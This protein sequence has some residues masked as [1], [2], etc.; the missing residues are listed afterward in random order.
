N[1]SVGI[2]V[3][4]AEGIVSLLERFEERYTEE[5]LHRGLC[6]Y[7]DLERYA[8]KLLKNDETAA[9]VAADIDEIFIDEYQDVNEIQDAIFKMISSA[10]AECRRFMV[11]DVKQSIYGFRGADPTIFD[12]Y[13]RSFSEGKEG[14]LIFMSENFR[15]DEGIVNFTNDVTGRLFSCGN[16]SFTEDDALRH[17]KGTDGVSFGN[18]KFIITERGDEAVEAE[19]ESVAAEAEKLMRGGRAADDIVILMRSAKDRAAVFENALRRHNIPVRNDTI[20]SFFECP[21]VLLMLCLIGM[22]N[23]PLYDIYTAGALRS[24]VFGFS[25]DEL[26][27]VKGGGDEPLYR[28][29]I[30][31]AED[32]SEVTDELR[33]KCADAAEIIN[34]WRECA[35]RMPSDEFV[36]MLYRKTGMEGIIAS[37]A[38]MSVGSVPLDVRRENLTSFYEYAKRF[39]SGS[40]RGV[41]RFLEYINDMIERGVSADI[42]RTAGGGCVK[43]MTIHQSKGLEFPVVFLSGCGSKRNA[44]DT[45]KSLLF[46]RE[47]GVAM[48][49][50][51][52]P[53]RAAVTDTLLRASASAAIEKKNDS[54]EMRILYVGLTRAKEQLYVTAETR[55]TADELLSNAACEARFFS[56]HT[57]REKKTPLEWILTAAIGDDGRLPYE[58]IGGDERAD[59]PRS[60][61]EVGRT[62]TDEKSAGTTDADLV[63][64]AK[65]TMLRNINFVYPY[66][67]TGGIPAKI[68]VS[69]LTPDYLDRTDEDSVPYSFDVP[70]E[71]TEAALA[72]TATHLFL[73]FCDFESA[74]KSIDAEADRLVTEGYMRQS[75]RL[76]I[77]TD[78]SKAFFRSKTYKKLASADR[79]WRE[80]RFNVP[81][82]ASEF[83]EDESAK[84]LY[85]QSEVLVQGVIDCMY[86]TG[87]EVT[88]IDYKTDRLT[89]YEI[90]H[91]D[92]AEEK[93]RSRH[94][95]QLNLYGR[96]AAALFGKPPTHLYVYSLAL[97]D[98]IEIDLDA[99]KK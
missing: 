5:K 92:A 48:K 81:F 16:V 65:E 33:A 18:V 52:D 94:A 53:E 91:R 87:G 45:S 80:K 32:G 71:K 78:E 29:L 54:E 26:I 36:L 66:E 55:H 2:T 89:P 56:S 15:C 59:E 58:I 27:V 24:P 97:G 99:D 46:D 96:A 61:D 35:V 57:V 76:L 47:T 86:V 17:A 68:S 77:R 21:E 73:Q 19:A 7:T 4:I 50:R 30:K 14:K 20:P 31:A 25:L 6:N 28:A 23:N 41:H 90:A 83:T 62:L 34:E 44:S 75:D 40:F 72:G 51:P 88:I 8:Y 98:E 74:A 42:K 93:L 63:S 10:R 85:A 9:E 13:R 38:N 49:I 1:K 60:F 3:S 84:R 64:A 22:S 95:R 70:E 39:E 11:G 79:V 67:R 69:R 43:I 82:P 37:R 12:K